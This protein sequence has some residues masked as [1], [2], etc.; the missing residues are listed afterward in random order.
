MPSSLISSG[1]KKKDPRY[2][3]LRSRPHT[4]TKC[5]LMFSRGVNWCL[6]TD[7]SGPTGCT[8]M[9]VSNYLSVLTLVTAF[10]IEGTDFIPKISKEETTREYLDVTGGL[11]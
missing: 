4:H 7:V 9:P 3:Y 11:H 5:G 8:E 10:V 6:F 2:A 1:S